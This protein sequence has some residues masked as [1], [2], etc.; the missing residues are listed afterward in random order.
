MRFA[1]GFEV[2]KFLM[3]YGFSQKKL[4]FIFIDPI[5][6]FSIGDYGIHLYCEGGTIRGFR[7]TDIHRISDYHSVLITIF[8]GCD[9]R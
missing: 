8:L 6:D 3:C 9:I 5:G 2:R 7:G 1:E 4:W